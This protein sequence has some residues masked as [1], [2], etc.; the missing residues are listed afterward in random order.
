MRLLFYTITIAFSFGQ[1]NV[2]PEGKNAF[3]QAMVLERAGNISE[4]KLI[5]SKILENNPNH[6]PSFFQIRSIFTREGDYDSAIKLVKNWVNNNPNDLQSYLLLGEYYFRK[7]QKDE[8]LAIWENFYQTKLENKTTYRLLFHTYARFGQVVAM[9]KLAKKGRDAFDEPHLF[10]IDL[11]NY[12]QSRQTY[13]RSLREYMILID[14]QKQYLQYVTDRILLMSDDDKTHSLIDSTLKF[15]AIENSNV[16]KILAGYYYKIGEFKN[17]LDQ[18]KIIGISKPEDIKR[19][20]SFAENLQKE[21]DFNLS[22]EAYHY[23]LQEL[24]DSNPSIIGKALL[25]LGQAYEDQIIQDQVRL[26]FVSWFPKNEFFNNKLIKSPDI[27][28]DLL[29]NTIE[30]YQSILALLPP[31]N[32]TAMV[33]YRLGEIQSKIIRDYEGSLFAYKSALDANPNAK[34]RK[35]I[36]SKIGELNLLSGDYAQAT[37][38]FRTK[39]NQN[40]VD[41]NTIHYINSLLYSKNI[42]QPLSLLDTVI[43]SIKPNHH[44]FNDLLEVHDLIVNYYSNGTRDDKVAFKEFFSAEGLIRQHKIPEAISSLKEISNKYP[45]ALIIPLSKLRLAILFVEF[46]EYEQALSVALSIDDTTL[47]DKGLALAG[48]IEERFLGNSEN[49]LK[50]YYRLLSECE[51]SLLIEPVR[52]NIRKLSKLNES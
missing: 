3:T 29:I 14:H 25:G 17:A 44:F 13:N 26:E 50:Y 46:R 47:K 41:D 37:K 49:A 9:E 51:S 18:Q 45:D 32:T 40:I 35:L 33:H 43:I 42:D 5:Y 48:E 30:H 52:L 31:S 7:Q 39:N 2:V 28:N 36:Q 4:A 6:Q 12:Y 22:I 38:Y 20:M 11:A 1:I 19:W 21:G 27:K 34:L 16:R 23:L 10:A 24:G 15:H 8:A